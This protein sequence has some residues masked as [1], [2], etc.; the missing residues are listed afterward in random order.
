MAKTPLAVIAMLCVVSAR[1]A[2]PASAPG[3]ATAFPGWSQLGAPDD[4]LDGLTRDGEDLRDAYAA[5]PSAAW[6]M[7]GLRQPDLTARLE[8]VREAARPR[9]AEAIGPLSGLLL[10]LDQPASLRA[11][12]ALGLGRV[13][14]RSAQPSLSQALCDPDASVRASAAIA[15]GRLRA[16]EAS[17][18]LE[19]ALLRDP[20]WTVR[21]AAAV[22]LGKFPGSDV[23]L[24]ASLSADPAWQVRQQAA[25]SLQARPTPASRRALV[26][27]L[28]DPDASV[29]ASAAFSIGEIGTRAERRALSLAL[30]VETDPAARLLMRE[31]LRSALAKP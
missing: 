29:R 12:A 30:R 31:A 8:A 20:A 26:A 23:P 1:A 15:L 5:P 24:C 19:H 11:A 7:R 10:R 14:D 13:G 2:G 18:D 4:P 21:Y 6:L 17:A 27:A 16:R 9:N 3:R 25:R 28:L 22:A